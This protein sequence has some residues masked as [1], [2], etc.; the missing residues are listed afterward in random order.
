MTGSLKDTSVR[1]KIHF[2]ETPV[3]PHE[4]YNE[5]IYHL[6]QPEM[7]LIHLM[8]SISKIAEWTD[9]AKPLMHILHYGN[10]WQSYLEKVITEEVNDCTNEG[11]LF[12]SNSLGNTALRIYLEYLGKVYIQNT[13]SSHI[14]YII[15][16][17]LPCDLKPS[18]PE[19]YEINV[20][21]LLSYLSRLMESFHT[22]S[23]DISPG[24]KYLFRF[25]RFKAQEKFG[26]HAGITAVTGFL[27][28]RFL[29]PAIRDPLNFGLCTSE[30]EPEDKKTLN[31]LAQLIQKIANLSSK[32]RS[33]DV[34]L[35]FKNY[36]EENSEKFLKFIDE[37]CNVE[38]ISKKNPDTAVNPLIAYDAAC[39]VQFFNQHTDDYNKNKEDPGVKLILQILDP[40]NKASGTYKD[41]FD[42]KSTKKKIH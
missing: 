18:D 36:I 23:T 34:Y 10:C 3:L 38:E 15:S 35:P 13:L 20:A 2:T 25:L 24:M 4:E 26:E 9:I 6:M 17:K 41:I 29:V 21:N 1:L 32:F 30:I 37:I 5:F 12:R 28:L 31:S 16:S 22:C 42:T 14:K 7:K 33:D 11:T 39:L 27:F 40:I 8:E 19:D